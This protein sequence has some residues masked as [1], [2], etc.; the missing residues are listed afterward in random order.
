MID[1][2]DEM[3]RR[4]KEYQVNRRVID[5]LSKYINNH[6]GGMELTAEIGE[7]GEMILK[8]STTDPRL[9]KL[10]RQVEDRVCS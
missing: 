8:I 7:R 2:A 1:T 5:G 3:A 9:N 10:F 4:V 6:A